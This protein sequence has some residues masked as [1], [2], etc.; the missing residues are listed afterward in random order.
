MTANREKRVSQSDIALRADVS[1]STVSRALGSAHGISQQVRERVR[2]IASELGY[3]ERSGT[4]DTGLGAVVY[5]PMHPV[6][7]GLHQIFQEVYDGVVVAA[8]E[9]DLILYPKLLPEENLTLEFVT[10]QAE[11]HNTT[12]AL[13]FYADPNPEVAD[14]FLKNGNLVLVTN[15]DRDSRFDGVIVDNYAGVRT[16]TRAMVALGHRKL[17]F[18]AGNM[19]HAMREKIR[20]FQD[21]LNEFPDVTGSRI[22]LPHDRQETALE[23]FEQLFASRADRDWTGMICGN[24]L[25]AIGIMQAARESGLSIPEDFSIMGFDDLSWAAMTTPRLS[26]IQYSRAELGA[27]AVRLLIRRAHNTQAS[28]FTSVQGVRYICGATVATLTKAPALLVGA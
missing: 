13:L 24:D 10:A 21:A 2:R 5:L 19:R 18:V 23:H 27:E 11:A 8:Q 16:A 14:F 4:S 20:G 28:V 3:S 12:N 17:L 1:I 9:S 22:M 15:I 25:M 26:T 6:T 7:R